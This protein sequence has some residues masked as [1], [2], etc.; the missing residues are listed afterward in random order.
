MI[1]FRQIFILFS[2]ILLF[3]LSLLTLSCFLTYFN[4]GPNS[5]NVVLIIPKGVGV[6]QISQI[7]FNNQI[8]D[9][10]IIFRVLART[11]NRKMSLQAVEKWQTSDP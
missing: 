8:I 2:C 11:I 6:E 1:N 10:P 9:R 7:L 5:K 4:A 3:I